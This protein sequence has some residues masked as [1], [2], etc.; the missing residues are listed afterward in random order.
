MIKESSAGGQRGE[1]AQWIPFE[2]PDRLLDP[3]K[4]GWKNGMIS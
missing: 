4:E 3:F 2:H 1:G